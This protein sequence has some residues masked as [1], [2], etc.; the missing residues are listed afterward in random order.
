MDRGIWIEL[1]ET[2]NMF[3][4]HTSI[5][6]T[7]KFWRT[8]YI[9]RCYEGGIKMRSSAYGRVIDYTLR[10]LN[11]QEKYL[12]AL[13]IWRNFWDWYWSQKLKIYFLVRL[14]DSSATWM[15]GT[16][17]G[18]GM[19]RLKFW[20]MHWAGKSMGSLAYVIPWRGP[21]DKDI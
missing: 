17:Q 7:I 10:Q 2:Q 15:D 9:L 3:D 5:S 11:K 19:K 14:F 13:V 8:C 6:L 4:Q 18:L 1:S 16:A 20:M 12:E 21:L